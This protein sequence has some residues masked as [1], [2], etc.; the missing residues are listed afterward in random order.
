MIDKATTVQVPIWQLGVGVITLIAGMY[1]VFEL[2][3]SDTRQDIRQIRDQLGGAVSDARDS[4][5]RLIESDRELL[6][7]IYLNT[8][9]IAVLSKGITDI[10]TT[11]VSLGD[12]VARIDKRLASLPPEEGSFRVVGDFGYGPFQADQS[13]NLVKAI[14]SGDAGTVWFALPVKPVERDDQEKLPMP[15]PPKN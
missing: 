1:G 6:E 5:L 12:T 10:Q 11:L 8:R 7:K 13:G 9:E 2:A 14:E 15:M 4:E 3:L